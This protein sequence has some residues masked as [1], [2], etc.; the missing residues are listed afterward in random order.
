MYRY[1]TAL[2]DFKQEKKTLCSFSPWITL[3][4]SS[5]RTDFLRLSNLLGMFSCV[6]SLPVFCFLSLLLLHSVLRPGPAPWRKPDL[7]PHHT[8]PQPDRPKPVTSKRSATPLCKADIVHK[9]IGHPASLD[10]ST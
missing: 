8:L 2:F 10:T 7:N 1:S 3:I 4:V 9:E 6:G 5:F